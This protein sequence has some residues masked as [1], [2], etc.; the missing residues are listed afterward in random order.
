MTIRLRLTLWYSSL[1]AATMLALGVS[2]YFFIQW[3]T[4]AGVKQQLI[5]H[6]NGLQISQRLF[7]DKKLDLKLDLNVRPNPF[8]DEKDLFI[9]LINYRDGIIKL[10]DNL[11][12]QNFTIPYPEQATKLESGFLK[13]KTDINKQ[14][15]S[16]LIYQVPISSDG[17][18]I[19]LLQVGAFTYNEEKMLGSLRMILFTSSLVM[20]VLAFSI[21]LLIARQ[22]LRPV[23]RVI[24]ATKQI[25]K[26]SDL[27][28]RIPAQGPKDELHTLVDTLNVMLSRLEKAYNELDEAYMA[29]RRFVSDASHELRTPL[30]TIRGNIDL[31][32]HMWGR[33]QQDMNP[34]SQ[35]A[36][37]PFDPQHWQMSQEAM[38]DISA[39][40]KR[41]STMVNDLLALARADAG[42][43]MEK[44]NLQL[45][46]LVEEVVRRAQLLP[47]SAEWRIDDLT[48]LTDVT[49][50]GNYEYLQQLLFIFIEN[51]FKYTTEG[52]VELGVKKTGQH[53]GIMIKDT[54]IGMNP[55][56]VPHV[57]ERFYRA[58]ESRGVTVGTGLGLSIAKWIID[59]HRG[60]VEVVTAEG[61]GT[62]FTIW[63]PIAYAEQAASSIIEENEN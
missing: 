38:E 16:M 18:I 44:K 43:V 3:N 47:R 31:L 5:E 10:S 21:G 49:L 6:V 34:V 50:Y 62:I 12:S 17:Q 23:E 58:D 63:L 7:Y 40:A 57:F 30:T 24:Q 20:L 26:G 56:E 54:G 8:M 59:E 25:E 35:A 42:Y 53:V 37:Y 28:V 39:E 29:Q 11:F 55:N 52:Y 15:F 22:A 19:G 9:Q 1:L 32:Q 14:K 61:K 51:A 27:S 33:L 41:M 13:V 2:I 36:A 48:L 4:Y 46:P 60:T 45:L